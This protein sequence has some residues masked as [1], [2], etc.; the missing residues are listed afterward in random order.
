MFNPESHSTVEELDFENGDDLG[1]WTMNNLQIVEVVEDQ[2]SFSQKILQ[3]TFCY[4]RVL[5][6]F[7][8]LTVIREKL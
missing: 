5:R 1:V 8:L 4:E 2:V 6:T 3:A 7:S